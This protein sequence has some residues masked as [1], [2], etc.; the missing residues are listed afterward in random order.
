MIIPFAAISL[1][2]AIWKL[3]NV[4]E[5]KP[6][7]LDYFSLLLSALG[8][9]GLLYGFSNAS[10][11]GWNDPIVVTTLAVGA[12]SFLLFVI[13]QLKLTEPLLNLRTYKY[14]MF[15]LSSI[16][17]III[18]AAMFSGMILTPAYVQDVRGISPLDSGLLMLPGALIMGLMSPITG[19][20]FDKFGPKALALTG[21]SITA[22]TTYMLSKLQIDSAYF[23]IV[24]LYALRM[25]GMSLVM[26]P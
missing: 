10:I 2:L 24:F 23:Y 22:L 5:T 19:R 16:I 12:V 4:M 3:K 14:P 6:V 15:A 25:L 7:K 20:M 26:M 11:S 17:S 8:F 21:L 13:R 1:V 9:G 18:A